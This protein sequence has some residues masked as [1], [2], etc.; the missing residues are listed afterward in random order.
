LD[1]LRELTSRHPYPGVVKAIYLRPARGEPVTQVDQ[2]SALAGQG[3][4]GDRAVLRI[5][6]RTDARRSKA[7]DITLLQ[8]EVLPTLEAWSGL[9]PLDAGLQ[10]RNLLVSGLNQAAM[11]SP[12]ADGNN[13]WAIGDEVIIEVT[14]PCEPCSKMEGVLGA[15]GYNMMRGNGGLTAGVCAGGLIRCGDLIRPYKSRD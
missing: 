9:A 3:L 5:A 11:R 12:F 7:R 4:E 6:A 1:T 10:R 15:G 13:L 8:A 14:G 2:V